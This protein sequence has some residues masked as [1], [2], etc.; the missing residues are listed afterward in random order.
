MGSAFLL[1]LI[2]AESEAQQTQHNWRASAE[3]SQELKS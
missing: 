1:L 2:V 3:N